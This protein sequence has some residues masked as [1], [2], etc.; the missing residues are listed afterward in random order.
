[1]D[2]FLKS[3]ND[4]AKEMEA[5]GQE[6]YSELKGDMGNDFHYMCK[7]FSRRQLTQLRSLVLLEGVMTLS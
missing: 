3:L 6:I 4:I 1:M 5:I 2:N 7:S